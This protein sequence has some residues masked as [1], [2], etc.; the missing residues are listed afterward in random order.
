M[1]CSEIYAQ[2][3]K[4]SKFAFVSIYSG[5]VYKI[6]IDSGQTTNS[7]KTSL[8]CDSLG[9]PLK[10]AS[11]A[12]ALN[13]MADMGWKLQQVLPVIENS[14]TG[15]WSHILTSYQYLFSKDY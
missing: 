6:K 10:F 13:Y 5:N 3:G 2:E 7:K 8:V 1:F 9:N 15:N 11:S 14:Y 12:A 4:K